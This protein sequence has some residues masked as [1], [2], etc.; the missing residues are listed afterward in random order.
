MTKKE[1]LERAKY[2]VR[3][4]ELGYIPADTRLLLTADLDKNGDYTNWSVAA[5]FADH[6]TA[7]TLCL[8]WQYADTLSEVRK[9]LR[10]NYLSCK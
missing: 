7:R 4:R 10:N 5:V 3:E 9:A 8:A 2:W 6:N 1:V